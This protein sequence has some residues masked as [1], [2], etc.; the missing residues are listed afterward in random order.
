ME[1]NDFQSWR[2]HAIKKIFIVWV[3]MYKFLKYIG[4]P[5]LKPEKVYFKQKYIDFT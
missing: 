2:L 4:T 3:Q 1:R 5:I